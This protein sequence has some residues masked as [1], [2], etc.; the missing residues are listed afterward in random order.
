MRDGRS[1]W[2][3][4]AAVMAALLLSGPAAADPWGSGL[5]TRE[6][7][8]QKIRSTQTEQRRQGYG[9]LGEIGTAEDVPLLLSA[10]TDDEELIRGMAELAIWGIWMRVDDSVVDPLFQVALDL[11][12][13]MKLA[14]AEAKFDEVLG[15]KPGFAEAWHRRAEVKVLGDRWAEAES[16]FR[17]A[18]DLNPYH[19]GALEGLGHCSL[20]RGR[21]ADAVGFFT[22]AL[23]LN[24]N[25]EGVL[26]ALK[27]ARAIAER[28]RT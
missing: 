11:T 4:M 21:A 18:V 5:L 23:E 17:Q 3:G 16:D 10:L 6:A 9:R 2:R 19:F 28:D 26:E 24:P 8:L 22:R 15:M 27:R 20:H 1:A 7:A 25:L 14:E 12:Q 13:Q